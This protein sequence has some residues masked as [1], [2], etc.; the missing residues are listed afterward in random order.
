MSQLNRGLYANLDDLVTLRQALRPRRLKPQQK[1][2][3]QISGSHHALQ[4]GRGMEFSEVRAYQPGDDVR[5]IDWRVTARTQKPHTKVFTEEQARPV[6]LCLQQSPELFFGSHI[7]FK[8][9]QALQLAAI[10]AWL[11]LQQNDRIGGYIFNHQQSHWVAPNHHQ[12]TVMQLLQQGLNLQQQLNRPQTYN[13][14][15]WL[16]HLKQLQKHLKPGGQL[17]LIGDL[18]G[19][20][21]A[22]LQQVRQLKRQH[23]L[24]AC[25]IYDRL[26]RQLPHLGVVK[27]TNGEQT[28]QL[29]SEEAKWQQI[30]QTQYENRLSE[31]KS[32]FLTQKVPFIE[33]SADCDPVAT[34][35]QKGVLL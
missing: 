24:I 7:R 19:M 15:L 31:I 1:L 26:E 20:S 32:Q 21:A 29:D 35:I 34:L 3:A 23:D 27:L 25:H 28:L 17:I 12:S 18:L 11:T 4:K 10:F 2:W 13:K 22:A 16:S 33:L 6:I 14:T 5:T 8:S 9:V 30:Y